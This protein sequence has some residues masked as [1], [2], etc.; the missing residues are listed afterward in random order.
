[1]GALINFQL[2]LN[3]LDKNKIVKGKKGTYYDLTISVSEKTDP[4]GNNVSAFDKETKEDRDAKTPRNYVGNGNVFWTDGV[5]SRA[6][7]SQSA[8][9]KA[10]QPVT[11]DIDLPF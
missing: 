4:Y 3:K 1:M 10:S 2:D 11:E 9:V 5:I 6:E 8:P 7:K